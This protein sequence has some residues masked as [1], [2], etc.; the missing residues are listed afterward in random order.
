MG[1]STAWKWSTNGYG[2]TWES[3][4]YGEIPHVSTRGHSTFPPPRPLHD[5]THGTPSPLLYMGV[6]TKAG[7]I[8]APSA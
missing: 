8:R 7:P 1:L 4:E 2:T 5:G 6:F 3:K